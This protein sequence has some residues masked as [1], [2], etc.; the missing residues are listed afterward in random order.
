MSHVT[1]HA[2]LNYTGPMSERP[3]FHANDQ[4]LDR[5]ALDPRIVPITD[6]RALRD[7][8]TL[9]REGLALLSCPT[10]VA[11]FRDADEVAEALLLKY[12]PA[13][14]WLYFSDMQRDEVLV[15]KRH[16]TD[17]SE[18]HHVPHSGFSDPRVAPGGEPRAS[19]EMR[20]IAYWFA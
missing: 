20:T 17:P 2:E 11:E 14:R 8:P 9:A 4:S 5:V 19:V 7:P 6:A 15:F 12:N 18:P 1:V 13:H 16:D 10:A 3:W